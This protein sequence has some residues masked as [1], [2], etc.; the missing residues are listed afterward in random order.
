[1]H[2]TGIE[3]N[4]KTNT[5]FH[6]T[7]AFGQCVSCS[8][9][10][11]RTYKLSRKKGHVWPRNNAR[12]QDALNQIGCGWVDWDNFL[13]RLVLN[14]IDTK[15]LQVGRVERVSHLENEDQVSLGG[16]GR[17]QVEAWEKADLSGGW[18]QLEAGETYRQIGKTEPDE[19]RSLLSGR[20]DL[21]AW[22]S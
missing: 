20:T 7:R 2:K 9:C 6:N 3:M 13:R 22:N 16:I 10:L 1:M 5:E 11:E 17:V 21:C 8:S 4:Q 14:Q 18:S 12:W 19:G 15:E